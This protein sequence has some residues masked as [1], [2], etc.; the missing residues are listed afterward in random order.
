MKRAAS[1]IFS[2]LLAMSLTLYGPS[3]TAAAISSDSAFTMEICADGVSKVV[4]VDFDGVPVEPADGCPDC[5]VCC[6][7]FA[8]QATL[9]GDRPQDVFSAKAIDALP[10]LDTPY[11]YKR[12]T[13]PMPRGPPAMHKTMLTT[14]K[15]Y[16]IDQVRYGHKTRSDGRPVLKDATA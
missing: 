9:L 16:L 3:R 2:L 4:R 14:P 10:L 8:A 12:N 11:I 15:L 7:L 6:D 1:L 13:R 5:P